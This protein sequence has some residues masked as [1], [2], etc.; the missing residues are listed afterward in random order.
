MMVCECGLGK[1]RATRPTTRRERT[2]W[3]D[4]RRGRRTGKGE[5][6][7]TACGAVDL[8]CCL[9]RDSRSGRGRDEGDDDVGRGEEG[10]RRRTDGT[11]RAEV[12]RGEGERRMTG[13]QS[14]S[15]SCSTHASIHASNRLNAAPRPPLPAAAAA[16]RPHARGGRA[17]Q[18]M[19]DPMLS[20]E[21]WRGTSQP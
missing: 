8:R 9:A 3:D 12:R 14:T 2:G 10:R 6:A 21:A 20:V 18:I 13:E 1:W 19:C 11:R 17:I 4:N 15:E 16:T 5:T 7:A